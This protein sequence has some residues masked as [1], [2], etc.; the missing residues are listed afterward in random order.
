[1]KRC[2]LEQCSLTDA[3]DEIKGDM[4]QFAVAQTE[5]SNITAKMVQRL[6][7]YI[8]RGEKEHDILFDRTRDVVKRDDVK[9]SVKWQH[10]FWL[11]AGLGTMFG[12]VLGI[13]ELARAIGG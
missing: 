9:G 10:L 12:I 8:E 3:I 7:D 2:D 13:I 1:M 5:Q 4:K 6:D 11:V